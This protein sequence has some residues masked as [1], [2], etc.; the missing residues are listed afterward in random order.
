MSSATSKVLS[1]VVDYLSEEISCREFVKKIDDLVGSD[2]TI[3]LDDRLQDDFLKL[4][5]SLALCV[6][7][8]QTYAQ[9]PDVYLRESDV[10]PIV[11]KF[12]EK[13][14]QLGLG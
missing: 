12:Q 8:D 7:D 1:T 14:E 5:E 13:V 6:W 3:G 9:F 2:E 4:H 11:T 10:K